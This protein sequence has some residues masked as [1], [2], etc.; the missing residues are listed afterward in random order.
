MEST[1]STLG[2]SFAV[3]L[4]LFATTMLLG[5]LSKLYNFNANILK[6]LVLPT[7]GFGVALGLNSGLQYAICGSLN[8]PQI[9]Q[10]SLVV[11]GSIIL[12]L[13]L[14]LLSFIRAPIEGIVPPEYY[15]K[16]GGVIA[17]AYYMFWAGMIGETFAGGFAQS[18]P[19]K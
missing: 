6:W 8:F 19:T 12:F 4:A 2:M 7:I 10:G 9:A 3:G 11:L 15:K 16:W 17:L 14:T 13:F 18:C 1:G 5:W